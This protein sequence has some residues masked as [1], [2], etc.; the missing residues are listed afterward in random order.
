[1][2]DAKGDIQEVKKRALCRCG[3]LQLFVASLL[4]LPRPLLIE[5][6]LWKLRASGSRQKRADLPIEE[7][8]VAFF[9]H[10]RQQI[11][12]GVYVPTNFLQTLR[13]CFRLIGGGGV[14]GFQS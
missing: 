12:Q 14:E 13:H 10:P 6:T 11:R 1:M 3:A 2:Y 8:G 9:V 5:D 4:L 7:I